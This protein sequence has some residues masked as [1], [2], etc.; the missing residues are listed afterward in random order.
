[1]NI[2]QIA[3][4]FLINQPLASHKTIEKLKANA[5]KFS[6]HIFITA[7]WVWKKKR[8]KKTKIETEKL[9]FATQL[10]LGT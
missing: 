4:S 9:Q 1:M 2:V 5:N 3:Q 6:K 10:T 8:H 7:K